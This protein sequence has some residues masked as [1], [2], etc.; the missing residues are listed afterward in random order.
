MIAGQPHLN[1][2]TLAELIKRCIELGCEH[3]ILP[4]E[5]VTDEGSFKVHFLLNIANRDFQVIDDIGDNERV[6]PSFIAGLERRLGI[7][8]GL[9]SEPQPEDED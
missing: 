9:P 4:G 1:W 8:T 7:T 6:P 5:V 3:R 2:P